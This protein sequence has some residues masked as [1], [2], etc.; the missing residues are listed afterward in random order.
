MS[1]HTILLLLFTI[2]R[3]LIFFFL[4]LLGLFPFLLNRENYITYLMWL[5][6]GLN[7]MME[8]KHVE[9]CLAQSNCPACEWK[10]CPLMRAGLQW[11]LESGNW[12][13][14]SHTHY[15]LACHLWQNPL[16]HLNLNFF[17]C[18]TDIISGIC[19]RSSVF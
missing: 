17:I 4:T 12:R 8:I 16:N 9:Q 18:K 3:S 15:L 1:H 13:L 19:W 11:H 7:R 2:N 5:L 14:E 10:P 6:G